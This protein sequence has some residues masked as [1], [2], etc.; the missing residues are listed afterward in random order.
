MLT[1]KTAKDKVVAIKAA[2]VKQMS[3]VTT[4]EKIASAA[5]LGVAV[6][7]AATAIGSSLLHRSTSDQAPKAVKTATN[8]A[9]KKD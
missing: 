2:A 3:H 8:A 1:T 7:A 4:N 9:S 5:V 6:G